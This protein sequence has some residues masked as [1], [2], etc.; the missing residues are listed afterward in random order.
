MGIL[1]TLRAENLT[2]NLAGKNVLV[3]GGTQGIGAA[4]ISTSH[5]AFF[6]QFY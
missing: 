2:H 6:G 4:G 1:E 5:F 3:T